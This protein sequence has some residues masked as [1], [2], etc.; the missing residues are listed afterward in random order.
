MKR[1]NPITN[2][3]TKTRL[4]KYSKDEWQLVECLETGIVYLENP[5]A[6]SQLADEFAW[7]KTYAIEKK[8]RKEREPILSFVS[9]LVEMVRRRVNRRKR[10]VAL[11][12]DLLRKQHRKHGQD[13]KMLDVGCGYGDKSE[14]ILE[15]IRN[16]YEIGIVPCGLE[17]SNELYRE[18]SK[19]FQGYG[20][21]VIHGS[22]I[23]A[24][25]EVPDSSMDLILICSFLEHEV[26]PLELLVK[27]RE[28][29]N[30]S[31]YVVIKVPNYN[32]LNR[33][34]RQG[35]WCGFRYPD[36][37]NYFTPKTLR[38]IVERSGME[39]ARMSFFDRFPTN[40]NMYVIAKRLSKGP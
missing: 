7:E 9:G 8:L 33:I 5:P 6:T 32:C 25:E 23:E 16:K 2:T 37:V 21:N 27:C 26:N 1:I 35:R 18:A 19:V 30:E 29:L 13:L 12:I 22:A 38:L 20:G 40:D 10:V 3:E 31:G 14:W 36:H 34:V 11:S 24:I 39:V 4:S 15:Q 17:I 28:K